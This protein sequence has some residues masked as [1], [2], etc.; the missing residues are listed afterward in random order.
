MQTRKLLKF[1]H[2]LGSIGLTGALLIQLL[3]LGHLPPTELLVEYAATREQVGLV[4]QWVLFPAMALV[5]V[6]GLLSMAWTDAY[7]NA[8]WVWAKLALGLSVFEGTL[9]AIQGP[10]RK[11]AAQAALALAG[12]FDL[13]LLG[14]TT[15][16]EFKSTMVVLVVAILN[17]VLAVFRPKFQRRKRRDSAASAA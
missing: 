9:V 4:S 14:A 5:L 7:H 10:A 12:E 3:M 15:S 16:A 11:E 2:T 1:L 8:G 13:S 17:V 6:S